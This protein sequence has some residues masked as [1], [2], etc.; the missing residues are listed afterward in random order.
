[1]KRFERVLLSIVIATIGFAATQAISGG[2][3]TATTESAE[4]ELTMVERPAEAGR[5]AWRSGAATIVAGDVASVVSR[6]NEETWRRIREGAAGT[7]IHEVLVEHDS[8]LARWPARAANPLRVWVG[9][10]DGLRN[11]NWSHVRRVR[12]AFEEW[13]SAGIPVRFTFVTD[14]ADA[15]IH[16][17]W[18]EQFSGMIAGKTVWARDRH[19]WIVNGTITIALHHNGGDVLSGTAITAIA[20]HEVGH[21]LGLDHTMDTTNIMTP[22]VRVRALSEADRTTLRL[23]YSLP[24][25]SLVDRKSHRGRRVFMSFPAF[26]QWLF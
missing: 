22:K 2:R 26:L 15:D 20:L 4:L 11:W 18:T 21:L 6:D 3:V 12:D 19:W 7:Y 8:S 16:V 10:G 14:S 9:T 13:S 1:M 24:P 5:P 23:L 25:G 17:A